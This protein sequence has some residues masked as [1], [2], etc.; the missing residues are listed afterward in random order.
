M[1]DYGSKNIAIKCNILKIKLLYYYSN[2]TL[3]DGGGLGMVEKKLNDNRKHVKYQ[4][5]A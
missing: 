2:N 1:K 3:R 4:N 5:D